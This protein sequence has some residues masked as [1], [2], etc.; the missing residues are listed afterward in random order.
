MKVENP[1]QPFSNAIQVIGPSEAENRMWVKIRLGRV[2]AGYQS[3]ATELLLGVRLQNKAWERTKLLYLKKNFFITK[4]KFVTK[5][6][7]PEHES[8]M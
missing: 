2:C 6:I 4:Y 8:I 7:Q 5:E 3:F 1:L